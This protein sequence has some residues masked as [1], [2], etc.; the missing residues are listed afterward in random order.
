MKS[1]GI[2]LTSCDVYPVSGIMYYVSFIMLDNLFIVDAHQDIAYHLN[3]FKRDFINPKIRCKITLPNLK[4]GKVKLL[5]NTIFVHPKNKPQKTYEDALSQFTTYKMLF[6]LY[7]DDIKK[8]DTFSK[9]EELKNSDKV[10]FLTMMEGADPI[11]S[12]RDLTEFYNKGVRIIGLAWND[13]NHYASGYETNSGLSDLGKELILRM[14]E[15]G[16]TLDLSH[17]NEICFWESID[18]TKLIPIATHSNAKSLTDH[19]R[20][21]NDDQLKAIASRGGVIGI[22]LFDTFLKIEK[23]KPTLDELFQH[24]DYIIN[25]CGED[26][27]GIGSDLDGARYQ[28]FPKEIETVA[29]L[30][31]IAD[32]FVKKGYNE[33]RIK[34]IMGGNFLRVLE[35]NLK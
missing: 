28:D 34:K 33:G 23:K 26:H 11:E 31:K 6:E 19:P 14:N 30:P 3:F 2:K 22:V 27:V 12:P 25:L 8:V 18:L 5:F 35:H 1:D 17:L 32:F 20:N 10:G 7:K 21:L 4:K 9:I 16:I 24:T 15:L 29:D 13:K